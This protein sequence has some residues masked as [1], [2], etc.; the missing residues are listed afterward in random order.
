MSFV[1]INNYLFVCRR[2]IDGLLR[3]QSIN[4]NGK[5]IPLAAVSASFDTWFDRLKGKAGKGFSFD[6]NRSILEF[7]DDKMRGN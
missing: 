6:R 4:V 5:K 1:V 3:S 7:V 2:T